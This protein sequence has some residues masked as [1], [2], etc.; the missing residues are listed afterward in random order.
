[1]CCNGRVISILEGGYGSLVTDTTHVDKRQ[2]DVY[3]REFNTRHSSTKGGNSSGTDTSACN[4]SHAE[5]NVSNIVTY[6][7]KMIIMIYMLY[8][9]DNYWIE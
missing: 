9:V 3:K 2:K 7:Y 5:A 1:M 8:I 6:I 4:T